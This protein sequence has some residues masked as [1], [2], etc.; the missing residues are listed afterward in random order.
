MAGECYRQATSHRPMCHPRRSLCA[1]PGTYCI[2]AHPWCKPQHFVSSGRKRNRG[3]SCQLRRKLRGASHARFDGYTSRYADSRPEN[4]YRTL[5]HWQSQ[6]HPDIRLV[7]ASA[8]AEPVPPDP[9]C[10][11]HRLLSARTRDFCITIIPEETSPVILPRLPGSHR[12][13][14]GNA[15]DPTHGR[16]ESQQPYVAS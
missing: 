5:Q 15:S 7:D 8:L 1:R 12:R 6:W 13:Q 9:K 11:P 4:S 10:Y 16:P 2:I 14:P 3:R